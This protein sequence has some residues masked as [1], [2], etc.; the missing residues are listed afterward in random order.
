M[1]QV[2]NLKLKSKLYYYVAV[3]TEVYDGD[4]ITV[5]LDLGMGMWRH[6][7]KI[8]LWRVD[9]PELRGPERAQGLVA[10]DFV[11]D[12]VLHQV[13]LIRTILDKRGQDRSGK[14]GRLLG[15][16]SVEDAQGNIIHLNDLLLQKGYA[17]PLAADGSRIAAALAPGSH[18]YPPQTPCPYCG[19]T[20]AVDT[21]SGAVAICPNCLDESFRTLALG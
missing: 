18:L 16:V 5:D 12:L 10:R 2:A 15:E 13:V 11:R 19:E 8:R 6:H 9:T 3:V 14:F 17:V 21:A 4:T 1:S 20:R 7:Q